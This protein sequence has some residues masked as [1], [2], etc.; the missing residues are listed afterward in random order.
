MSQP[1]ADA[2]FRPR[3]APV[4]AGK[5]RPLWS[6]M[7]PTYDSGKYL[8]DTLRSVLAQDPGYRCSRVSCP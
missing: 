7:I 8:A 4:R 5:E 1:V 3:I 6:V 2:A